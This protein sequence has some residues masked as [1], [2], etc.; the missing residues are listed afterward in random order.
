MTVSLD[1][2]RDAVRWLIR[3]STSR[4]MCSYRIASS[5]L[6]LPCVVCIRT[7]PR[8][9]SPVIRLYSYQ[10]GA[11]PWRTACVRGIDDG[12]WHVVVWSALGVE[13]QT[14]RRRSSVLAFAAVRRQ[15]S[16][17]FEATKRHVTLNPKLYQVKS[18][19]TMAGSLP[20]AVHET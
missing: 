9:R 19:A 8:W 11:H 4:H 12:R 20:A 1:R 14:S 5:F 13:H 7:A 15:W 6:L 17:E 10:S 16:A 3:W 2:V 18:F